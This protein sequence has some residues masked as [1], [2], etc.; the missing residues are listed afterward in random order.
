MSV[1]TP[2]TDD[3]VQQAI[4]PDE[5]SSVEERLAYRLYRHYS[6]G[7]RGR[8]IYKLNDGTYTENEPADMTT[9]AITYYGGHATEVTATEV[10]SLTAAGYGEY[11]S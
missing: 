5:S 2:P 7:P 4:I 6:P 10:A 1:F 8:N 9:V 3:F 11:I